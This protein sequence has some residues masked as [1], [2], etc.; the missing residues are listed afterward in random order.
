MKKFI[1]YPL[2]MIIPLAVLLSSPIIPL[3]ALSFGQEVKL[4]TIPVDPRDFFRG[5]YVALKFAIEEIDFETISQSL[6]SKLRIKDKDEYYPPEDQVYVSLKPDDEGIYN[7][8][9][10]SDAPPAEGVYVRG[11]IKGNFQ[12]DRV[13][14]DYG[15][16]LS[17]FYVK[18]NTGLELE[19]A[20]RKGQI[21][22]IAKVWKGHIVLDT[23][24]K[25]TPEQPE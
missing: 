19:D 4:S 13:A 9:L 22:A 25:K 10:V 5:D 14:I 1:K 2:I 23:I 12:R 8:A 21:L 3:A 24:L 17:R 7:V 18:E 16:N 20:A 15:N 6:L 11:R